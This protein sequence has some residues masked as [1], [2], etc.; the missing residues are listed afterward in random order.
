[1]VVCAFELAIGELRT[2]LEGFAATLQPA[3]ISE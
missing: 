1:M 2:D 3:A